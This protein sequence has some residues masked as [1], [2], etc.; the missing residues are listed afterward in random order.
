[1]KR[2]ALVFGIAAGVASCSTQELDFQAPVRDD[3]AFYASFEQPGEPGDDATKVYAN[4]ELRLRWDADDR[5]SIFNKNTYNQQ[6]R[7]LGETGANAGEF[8]KVES[9]EFVTGNALDNVIS[10]YPYSSQTTID[11][12]GAVTCY[13]PSEQFY[14]M[15]SFGPEA[16]PMMSVSADNVLQFK[17]VGGYLALRFYGGMAVNSITLEGHNSELLHGRGVVSMDLGGEPSVQMYFNPLAPNFEL[18]LTCQNPVVLGDTEAGTQE[19]WFVVPPVTFQGGFTVTVDTSEG[20]FKKKTSKTVTIERNRISR[21]A[22]M[23]LEV[24]TSPA[25]EFEDPAVKEVCINLWDTNGDGELSLEEAAA[26]TDLGTAFRGKQTIVKFNELQCFTGLSEIPDQAF[27]NCTNLASVVLPETLTSIGQSAFSFCPALTSVNLPESLTS[28]GISAFNSCTALTGVRFPESLTTVGS[29]AFQRCGLTTLEIPA[30]L[31]DIGENAFIYNSGLTAIHVSEANPVYD[32][33]GGCNALIHTETNDL[34]KACSATVVPNSVTSFHS[35]AYS[36]VVGLTSFDVPEQV[37]SLGSY[38]FSECSDLTSATIPAA[39]TYIGMNLF[40]VCTNLT[41]IVVAPDNPTYDSRD[42][43]NAVIETETNKLHA[44][45]RTTVI[46]ETVTAIGQEAY[47]DSE[48][49]EGDLVIPEWVTSVGQV[50]FTGCKKLET[51]TLP[52]GLQEIGILAFS[53]NPMLTSVT[54]LAPEPPT[55]VFGQFIWAFSSNAPDFKIYVPAESLEAYQNAEGW[56][57][58][59]DV[60]FPIE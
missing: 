49:L 34:L 16:N 1:M 51:V 29:S 39:T 58:H 43:C 2:F 17:N 23:K 60:I 36:G 9:A 53:F 54:C 31:T 26:V 48:Y 32:S 41:S 38:V 46:P 10:F 25:I 44:P 30:G 7:F 35:Y 45:C 55:L 19:F 5:V 59:T 4:E 11:E 14:R 3:V 6:Y 47:S 40:H 56:S 18:V 28:I 52:R 22:P 50:A 20:V 21:M 24:S 27:S 8:A 33:R 37:T 57:K 15:S 12:S 42:H 13:L